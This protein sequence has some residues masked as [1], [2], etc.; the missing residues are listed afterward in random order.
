MVIDIHGHITP[1]EMFRKYP[2]P[3][4]LGDIE[5]MLERKAQAGIELTIVGSPVGGGAMMPVEGVDNYAQTVD[6][7]RA[8]HE[9]LANTV[10]AHP[11]HLKAYVYT[12]PL[13]GDDLLGGAAETLRDDAFVGLIV[14]SSVRGEYLDTPRAD[15]FFAM[16]ASLDA[17]I[18]VHPPAHPAGSDK[19]TDFRVVEQVGRFCDVTMGLAAIVFAGWLEKYPT[20]R[21]IGATAGGALS[22]LTAKLDLAFQPRHWTNAGDRAAGAGREQG[23]GPGPARP[24]LH[25]ENRI[26]RPPSELLKRLYFDTAA[27][28]PLALLGNL[29]AAGASNVMFGTDSPPLMSPLTAEIAAINDLPVTEEDKRGILGANARRVFRLDEAVSR[30]TRTT[31][32]PSA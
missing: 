24:V 1:P 26:T 5:A 6:Q 18:L 19:V 28:G 4:S 32:P 10:R 27:P 15:S 2:M 8:F 17:P 31:G 13:G 22:L 14:N 11:R 25:Y 30:G 23:A 9:W 16:A 3:P 29:E 7:L 20:L 12:N 21:V